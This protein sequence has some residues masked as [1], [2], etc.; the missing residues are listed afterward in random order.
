MKW[1]IKMHFIDSGFIRGT[2][3]LLAYDM[4]LCILCGKTSEEHLYNKCTC[5]HYHAVGNAGDWLKIND[6]AN[7]Y[8]KHFQAITPS[9][10]ELL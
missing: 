10:T 7:F 1:M 8:L 6:L 5:D 3:K 2:R 9:N 4:R